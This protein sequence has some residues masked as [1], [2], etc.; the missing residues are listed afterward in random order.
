M[1]YNLI[2]NIETCYFDIPHLLYYSHIPTAGVSILLGLFLF[3]KARKS[4]AARLLL[5]ASILFLF[6]SV[7]D[8]IL[9]ISPDSRIVLFSWSFV[10]LLEMLVSITTFY[11]AYVFLEK[12][13]PPYWIKA[14]FTVI[15]S[16]YI[17]LIPF[18]INIPG[19]NIAVCEAQQ[20]PLINYFY[21]IETIVVFSIIV[22]LIQKL[23]RVD[24][25]Y[26]LPV[27]F[28]AIGTFFFVASFSGANLIGSISALINPDSP[29]NWKILQYGLFGMP[30]FIGFLAYLIV[31][32]K[33]FNIKLIATQALIWAVVI[34]TGSELFFAKGVALVLT[35]ITLLAVI[36]FGILIVR[37]V[38]R[39]VE[40]KEKLQ[41]LTE[42]L[43]AKNIKLAELD[44]LKN[45]FLAFAAHQLKS[46]LAAI[47]GFA[48]MIGDGTMGAVP[49]P[50]KEVTVKITTSSNRLLALVG[51]F[52]DLEKIESGKLQFR[53]EDV[54]FGDLV[55]SVFEELK[56][57]ATEIT[58]TRKSPLTYTLENNLKTPV[59]LK[60]DA[61]YLRQVIQNFVD[62]SIKYTPSG[63]T[64]VIVK[65]EGPTVLF[66]VTDSGIG[67]AK[68]LLPKLFQKFS[69]VTGD[70]DTK[71]IQGTGLGLYIAIFVVDSY[72]GEMWAESPGE[73]KGA[74]FNLRLKKN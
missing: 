13:T 36:I 43:E 52:L 72:H 45:E 22:Y 63:F 70:Q 50:A 66:S 21:L 32:Y 30:I 8:L 59:I 49:D 41:K 34:M 15:L 67:I 20:G 19:F 6:W 4:I 69:R 7:V 71:K 23:I 47:K 29:D 58:T 25:E 73:G 18:S 14:F 9:W 35:E 57:L 24:K 54:N 55:Q 39:E 60:A 64:K 40:Q 44:Q 16:S 10:N 61:Q 65:D 27:L 42:E 46:P 51:N 2:T 62:N 48:T 28:F 53:I 37:S 56:F 31:K 33:A 26:K 5:F 38:K 68:E 17:I 11:F 1:E 74:T 12:K 3:L